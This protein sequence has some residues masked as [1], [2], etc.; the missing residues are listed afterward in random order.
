MPGRLK[1]TSLRACVRS[2]CLSL[3]AIFGLR[4]LK[5]L[6]TLMTLKVIGRAHK[7]TKARAYFILSIK[8]T[9]GPLVSRFKTPLI[10]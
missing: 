1:V 6:I 5:D 3:G 9:I 4:E 8:G 7:V 2:F 10:N